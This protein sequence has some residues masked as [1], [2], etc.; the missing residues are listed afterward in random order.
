MN[1]P[2]CIP[3]VGK[4]ELEAVKEVLDS[5]WLA[6]GPKSRK[7]EEDFASYIGVKKAISLNSCTSALQLAIEAKGLK[8]E[9][10]VPSFTFSASANSIVTAGCKPVFCEI[11]PDTFNMDPDDMEKR[12]TGK[13]VGI[14]P[15]HYAGMSCD[16][17]RIMEIADKHGLTVIEDSAETL[18]GEFNGKKTGSFGI[19][20]FSFFPTKNI[21]TGEGGMITTDD[22]ELAKKISA[23]RGHGMFS[24]TWD[25]EKA[26]KP[27]FRASDMAGYNYRMCDIL[28]AIGVVQMGKIESMNERRRRNAQRLT[29]GIGGIDGL[30]APC[31]ADG[32]KHVYQMYVLRIDA[33]VIPRLAFVQ[34]LKKRGIGANVHFDPPVHLQP[35]YRGV[36]TS[37]PVT[38]SVAESVV[39]LPMYPQMT[40]EQV[41]YMIASVEEVAKG[42]RN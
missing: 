20:C 8:G 34:E 29:K 27:W 32:T 5:G 3:D 40:E 10:I 30:A 36:G 39:T 38:E 11:R 42:L 21:T 1:I 28:A 33:S 6:H 25:R 35:Y 18:G 17:G 22:E 16:M 24:D 37:L 2:L 19:G 9:I 13:T 26:T 7:F 14:M 23:L 41:D 12:I 15:V 4:E 31:E